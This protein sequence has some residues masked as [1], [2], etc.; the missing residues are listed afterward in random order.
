MSR[1]KESIGEKLF[2][3]VINVFLIFT[4]IVSLYPVL[5]V[6]AAS[7]SNPLQ[8]ILREILVQNI[9]QKNVTTEMLAEQ[10]VIGE[11]IKYALIIVATIPILLIYPFI[12]KYFVKG[13]LIGSIKA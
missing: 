7:L 13:M 10:K 5:Y 9:V 1:V 11:S 12:Q 2:H 3:G 4:C 6:L 8:L